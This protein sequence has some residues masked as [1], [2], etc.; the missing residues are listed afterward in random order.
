MD[1]SPKTFS[2]ADYVVFALMLLVSTA[3]GIFYAI[4]DRKKQNTEEYLLGGRSMSAYPV[5]FSLSVGFM[6]AVLVLGTPS[7]VYRY[8]TMYIWILLSFVLMSTV[9][10]EIYIPTFYNMQ[11]TS[12]YEYLEKRF[13]RLIRIEGT[14]LYMLQTVLYIGIV[15]YAPALA[16]N[17]VTGFNLWAAVVS[18]GIVCIVYSS[19]GGLKAV[20]WTDAIQAVVMLAG[21]LSIIIRGSVVMGGFENIWNKCLEG[22]RLELWKFDLDPRERHTAWNISFGAGFL[23]MALYAVN[24]GQVQRYLSCRSV[25]EAKKSIMLNNIGLTVLN[26]FAVMCGLIL[27]AYYQD[28]D[29]I[30]F[31]VLEKPDQLL[32]YL[33]LDIFQNY[34]GMPGLFIACVYSGSLSTVST[35]ITAMAS[36]TVED[37]VKPYFNWEDNTFTWVSRGLVVFYGGVCMLFAYLTSTLGHLLQA[38]ISVLGLV[39]GPL[40][41]LYT[42]GILFPFANSWGAFVGTNAGLAAAIWVFIGSRNYR[43]SPDFLDELSYSTAMCPGNFTNITT[44]ALTTTLP[45]PPQTQDNAPPEADLYALSYMLYT[46][47]GFC[48]T[49]GVGL[50]VSGIACGWYGRK[51]VDPRLIYPFFDHWVFKCLPESFKKA[52]RCGVQHDDEK[53]DDVELYSVTGLKENRATYLN[54]EFKCD[55][56]EQADI[57]GCSNF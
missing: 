23:F 15:I 5:A 43:P 35:A 56:T 1:F 37:F 26:V 32:P 34:P 50:L 2:V 19:L 47:W 20:I 28:C 22:G 17:A 41:G 25:K 44:A 38:A 55:K 42:L 13:S 39:G 24:Q 14:L 46:V 4:K 21:F 27:Y 12:V 7:E 8:G 48:W 49:L 30:S 40:L 52:M 6:S 3:I 31:K 53:K 18:T 57:N 51:G 54:P 36:V 11:L 45:S 16:L 29:P 10:A 33:V 9:T